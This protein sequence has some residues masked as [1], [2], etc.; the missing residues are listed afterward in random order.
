LEHIS[1]PLV[2]SDTLAI[3]EAMFYGGEK[4]LV[5]DQVLSDAD[6]FLMG[7]KVNQ[8]ARIR[9]DNSYSRAEINRLTLAMQN[10]R[11]PVSDI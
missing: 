6:R 4:E 9:P 10:L 2:P 1:D 11:Q 8:F 7:Q 5:I 3:F